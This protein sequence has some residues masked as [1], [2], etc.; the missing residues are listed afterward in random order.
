VNATIVQKLSA[1]GAALAFVLA[2]GTLQAQAGKPTIFSPQPIYEFGDRDSENN[3]EH[4]F[5]IV[6]LGTAPLE[7][8]D[9][10]TSCGCT[11]ADPEKRVLQPGEETYIKG[12]LNLE[13]RQGPQNRTIT[14]TSNDPDNP[15]YQLGFRGNAI[16]AVMTEP[17]FINLGRVADE[18][19]YEEKITVRAGSDSVSFNV[20]GAESTLPQIE[21]EVI[22]VTEG[23]LYEVIARNTEPLTE[24]NL[25]GMITIHTD[26]AK[27]PSY[28]VRFFAQVIGAI[29]VRPDALTLQ[30]NDDPDRTTTQFVRVAPGRIKDFNITEVHAPLDSIDVEIMPQGNSNY[31]LRVSN[32]PGLDSLDGEH[33]IIKTDS[34]EAPEL[35]VPFRIVRPVGQAAA[36]TN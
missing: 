2:S 25:N 23:Q 33:L 19:L 13:G 10:R 27:R 12:T 15:T 21:T 22:T 29:E 6:N 7:I 8:R 32:M 36:L 5:S 11:A 4:E 1:A 18:T 30:H 31:N 3:V 17:Q 34:E 35:K 20:I 24:G 16:A 14:V 28:Q 26:Y 9:V